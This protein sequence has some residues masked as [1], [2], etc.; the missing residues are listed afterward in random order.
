MSASEIERTLVRLAHEIVEKN[1]GATT[2]GWSGSSAAASR[3]PS[4]WPR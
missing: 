3:W 4:G 1:D 2:W